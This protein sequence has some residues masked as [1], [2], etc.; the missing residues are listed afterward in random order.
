MNSVNNIL[1]FAQ[2]IQGHPETAAEFR[3]IVTEPPGALLISWFNDSQLVKKGRIRRVPPG[4]AIES[5]KV[6][7]TKRPDG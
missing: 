4:S 7:N 1:R 2:S 5:L 6:T 3:R